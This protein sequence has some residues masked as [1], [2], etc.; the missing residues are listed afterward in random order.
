VQI[1]VR[2][3]KGLG[4]GYSVVEHFCAY[5]LNRQQ[6]YAN[7]RNQMPIKFLHKEL[8]RSSNELTDWFHSAISSIFWANR[9]IWASHAGYKNYMMM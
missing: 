2:D 9:K 3:F 1:R 7:I 8:C 5:I 6:E 4:T